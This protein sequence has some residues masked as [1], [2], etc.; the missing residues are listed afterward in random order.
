[1]LIIKFIDH[2][3]DCSKIINRLK[4]KF[5]IFYYTD[6]N[7]K[8]YIL[9]E[10]TYERAIDAILKDI[11]D[12]ISSFKYFLVYFNEFEFEPKSIF[13]IASNIYDEDDICE[14]FYMVFKLVL[15]RL[16][17]IIELGEL[18]INILSNKIRNIYKLCACNQIVDNYKSKIYIKKIHDSII[19]LF[20]KHDNQSIF[21]DIMKDTI[22][23]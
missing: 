20:Q 17:F 21:H 6:I 23:N 5:A 7:N 13:A 4:E 10:H 11:N 14:L 3:K 19:V 12:V 8:C 18:Y 22:K 16:A 15:I 2:D 9:L 1:M